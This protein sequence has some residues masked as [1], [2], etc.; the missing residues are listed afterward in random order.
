[1]ALTSAIAVAVGGA[2]I[3]EGR[4]SDRAKN[5]S[6]PEQASAQGRQSQGARGTVTLCS[7]LP[8]DVARGFNRRYRAQR[9]RLRVAG[10]GIAN[11][12][13]EV[14]HDEFARLLRNRSRRCDVLDLDVIWMAEFAASRWLRD[15]TPL[16]RRR[17]DEFLASPLGTARYRGRYVGVPFATDAGLLYYRSDRIA[18]VPDTWQAVYESARLNG[19]IVYQGDAYEGL[20]VNFLEI[21]FAGGGSVL[22]AD[23]RGSVINSA[24]NLR[25][26]QF[27]VDGIRTGAAPSIVTLFQEF[28][29]LSAFFAGGP[30][31][32]RNWPFAYGIGQQ[33][34]LAGKFAVAPLPGFAGGG[35]GGVLGG[36]NLAISAYS[37]NPRGAALAIN[38]LTSPNAQRSNA[39]QFGI[40]PVL[41]ASYGDPV[42][43]RAL[44]FA[45]QVRQA[46]ENA[47]TRP[48][49]P[50]WVQISEAIYTN[51]N[52]ALR[53]D[54]TPQRAL[55]TANR[56]INRV[57]RRG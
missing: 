21:A 44:P 19:G 49:M 29:T 22:S 30:V 57:L 46:I 12:P 42:V 27:M 31:Y 18:A 8:P 7:G 3:A 23:G 55:A 50:R 15:V 53:G 45:A 24:A 41:K 13:L 20:T 37:R 25:A 9:V 6:A 43:Q 26:L 2:G 1:V 34:S 51:V 10:E 32:M 56:Q 28:P 4:A 38:Y 52:A 17:R 11:V 16:I 54:L 47:R 36:G 33:T 14:A 40:A 48:V 39:A 35:Q 5:A